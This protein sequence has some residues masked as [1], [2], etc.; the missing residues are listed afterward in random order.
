M[1]KLLKT[2]YYGVSDADNE[3]GIDLMSLLMESHCCATHSRKGGL[4]FPTIGMM[5][6][7]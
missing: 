2:I 1:F 7:E 3:D 4:D 5:F 6:G